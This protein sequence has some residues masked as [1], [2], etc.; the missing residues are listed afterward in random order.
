MGRKK[1]NYYKETAFSKSITNLQKE[2]G[3]TEEYVINEL[4]DDNEL[5]LI[6]NIQTYQSYKSGKRTPRDFP[7]MLVAFSKFYGVTTDYLLQLEETPNHQVKAVQDATGLSEHATRQLMNFSNNY[8]D[9]FKMIDVLFSN[10]SG[11]DITFFINLYNEIYQE[12]KD[13]KLGDTSSSYDSEKMQQR[14]LRMQQMYNYISTTARTGMADT[15][16]KQILVEEDVI[17]YYNSEEYI[18]EL[19]EAINQYY[20]NTDIWFLKTKALRP[21]RFSFSLVYYLE[22]W[23]LG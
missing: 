20:N 23:H 6:N 15:F 5:P 18:N 19:S 22:N 3:Y 14:F 8:P 11:E 21:D 10:S 16:D 9:I 12:Y 2:Y 7:D 1:Y 17:N 13:I 4:K